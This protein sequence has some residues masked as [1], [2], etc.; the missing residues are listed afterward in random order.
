MHVVLVFCIVCSYATAAVTFAFTPEC[1]CMLPS[2]PR[3]AELQAALV[4]TYGFPSNYGLDGCHAYDNNTDNSMVSCRDTNPPAWCSSRWCYVDMNTC[5]VNTELCEAAHGHRGAQGSPHCRSREHS[6]SSYGLLP[7]RVFYSYTT[8][9]NIDN[10]PGNH[11]ISGYYLQAA[12]TVDPTLE[13]WAY[14][15]PAVPAVKTNGWTGL[16][17]EFISAVTSDFTSPGSYL[18]VTGTWATKQAL[19]LV[20]PGGSSYTAC[21]YDVA[22][23]NIDM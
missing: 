20:G 17:P 2:S 23:G 5:P 1:P 8:C 15:D 16:V 13:H 11:S 3:Y 9:G 18:N 4:S 19:D 12:V 10:F 21:I 6:P 7:A 14:K 22:L